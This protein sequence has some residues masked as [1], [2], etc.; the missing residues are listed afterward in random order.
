MINQETV[1]IVKYQ[2]SV[3]EKTN[4][5]LELLKGVSYKQIKSIMRN[6]DEEIKKKVNLSVVL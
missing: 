1:E 3:N 5:I 6:V 2:E 4:S